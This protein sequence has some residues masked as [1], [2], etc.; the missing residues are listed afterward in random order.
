[1]KFSLLYTLIVFFLFPLASQADRKPALAPKT[2][3]ERLAAKKN[4][5]Q[6]LTVLQ[7]GMNPAD[8]AFLEKERQKLKLRRATYLGITLNGK[9]SFS[10]KGLGRFDVRLGGKEINY[11]GMAFRLNQN[12]SFEKNVEN[13]R[14]QLSVKNASTVYFPSAHADGPEAAE[15]YRH[16][17]FM[18]AMALSHI[19]MVENGNKSIDDLANDDAIAGTLGYEHVTQITDVIC[20]KTTDLNGNAEVRGIRIKFQGGP[21]FYMNHSADP[22]GPIYTWIESTPNDFKRGKEDT[23]S[24]DR[25]LYQQMQGSYCSFTDNEAGQK[26]RGETLAKLKELIDKVPK[27]KNYNQPGKDGIAI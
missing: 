17:G 25:Q 23:N 3:L 7:I 15:L 14:K 1:M 4:L 10:V 19:S 11:K 20:D 6:L 18:I 22:A 24:I 12:Y 13:F 27:T 21:D 26:A 5:G 16:S 9:N 2:P 8:S